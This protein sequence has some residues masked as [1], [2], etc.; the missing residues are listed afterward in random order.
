M[1]TTIGRRT[2]IS[3][4]P[5]SAPPLTAPPERTDHTDDQAGSESAWESESGR[6]REDIATRP[7]SERRSS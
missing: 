6:L 3:L 2:T 5:P 4:S 1:W 7:G